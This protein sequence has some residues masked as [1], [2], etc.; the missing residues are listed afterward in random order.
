MTK[1]LIGM[2]LVGSL[3]GCS[4]LNRSGEYR[5]E[6]QHWIV[7]PPPPAAPSI[8]API[9]PSTST[10]VPAAMPELVNLAPLPKPAH[11]ETHQPEEINPDLA[12]LNEALGDVVSP[13][14]GCENWE[15][16]VI[17][18]NISGYC[19]CPLC[20]GWAR[21][22]KGKPVYSAGPNKGKPKLV[23]FTASGQKAAV[24][25]IAADAKLLPFGAKVHVNGYGYGTV[26]DRGEAIQGASL[27][28]FFPSH[29]AAQKWGRKTLP[30]TVWL[31]PADAKTPAPGSKR[32]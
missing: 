31:P 13:P 16:K 20:C 9:V 15:K 4:N 12:V 21:N 5:R 1:Y 22:A 11:E 24:G 7:L 32:R 18:M 19:A 6:S 23:G 17:D 14:P 25:T 2:G 29:E 10:P 27:D 28:L 30:V 26:Q 3:I 8:A